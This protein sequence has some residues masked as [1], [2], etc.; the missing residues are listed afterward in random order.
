MSVIRGEEVFHRRSNFHDVCLDCEM[1]C[2]E[3][4]DPCVW[5]VSAK[6]F[7]SSRNEEG[8]ILTPDRK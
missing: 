1:T 2:I 3:E 5:Q 8:V 4:L 6:R 7:S